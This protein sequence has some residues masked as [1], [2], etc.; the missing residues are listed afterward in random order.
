MFGA[1]VADLGIGEDALQETLA[2]A[3]DRS[4]YAR[5]LD[6]INASAH[7]L[8]ASPMHVSESDK[9]AQICESLASCAFVSFVV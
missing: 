1:A 4:R 2:E 6:Q 7:N 8:H 5:N 9:V 3:L